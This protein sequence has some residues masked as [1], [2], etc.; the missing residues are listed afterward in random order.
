[1]EI[2]LF[3]MAVRTSDEETSFTQE[4]TDNNFNKGKIMQCNV[5]YPTDTY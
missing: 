1:M 4:A 5:T 3:F 2:V